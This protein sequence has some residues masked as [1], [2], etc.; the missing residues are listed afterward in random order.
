[1]DLT[2][3]ERLKQIEAERITLRE[4]V[5]STLIREIEERLGHLQSLGI[6]TR[7]I[8]SSLPLATEPAA[9]PKP[10]LIPPTPI[11]RPGGVTSGPCRVCKFKTQ[12]AHDGRMHRAQKRKQPFKEADLKSL[13]L[14]RIS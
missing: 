10:N 3:I 8:F 7:Q 14:R 1:M 9:P 6:D 13:G 2:P 12:P 5:Q 11:K 4:E